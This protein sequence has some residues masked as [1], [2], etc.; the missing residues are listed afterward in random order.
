MVQKP[1]GPSVA[2]GFLFADL[3]GYSAFVEQHGDRAGAELLRTYRDLVRAA[4]AEFDGAEIRTEGDSFYLVFG[5][6]SSAVL[7]GL[8]ILEAAAGTRTPSGHPVTVGIGV[9]AGETVET[10]EGYVGS[11]VNIAARI[12]AVAGP[13]ELLVSDA[14]RSLT[15]SYLEVGFVPAGRRRLK[16]IPEQIGLY[17]VVGSREAAALRSSRPRAS[18][19]GPAL[20]VGVAAAVL[21]VALIA[22]RAIGMLEDIAEEAPRGEASAPGAATEAAEAS[23]TA[24]ATEG[25]FPDAAERALLS[26]IED[27]VR[28]PQCVRPDPEEVPVLRYEETEATYSGPMA[29]EAGLRCALGS[30]SE[31]DTVWYWLPTASWAADEFFFSMV[32][33]RS[34]APG[35]CATEDRAYGTWEFG[36]AGGRILCLTGSREAQLIW[37][38]EDGQLLAIANRGDGDLRTLYRWWRDHARALGVVEAP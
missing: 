31:P 26:R 19:R 32:G 15:R 1:G 34:A 25:A 23:G 14:V 12:C 30:T 3:R 4:T 17:R 36:Q 38:Y 37:T 33:T 35:D 28:A 9:H 27:V 16:G 21:L 2:R 5:S 24:S 13:G 11:V 10:E 7:C 22:P 6:P 18:L 29:I 8:S 20:A